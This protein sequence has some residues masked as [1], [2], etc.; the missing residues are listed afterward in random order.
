MKIKQFLETIE[1]LSVNTQKNYE[2]TLWQINQVIRGDEPTDEDIL[3][4]LKRYP[5]SSLHRH[6]AA[7]KAYVE[8]RDKELKD[9]GEKG[10]PW[11]F[12][13]RQFAAKRQRIPR[14]VSPQV[15]QEIIN[16]G[17]TEDETMFVETL[18]QLG[19]RISELMSI[20]EKKITA[21]GVQVITKGG[22][23]YL[24]LTTKE[25]NQTLRAYA[26]KKKGRV[27]PRTYSY[28]DQ[29]LKRLAEKAGHS[30]VTLHMIRHGRAVDLLR[31]GMQLTDVQQ[32]LHHKSIT[33]TA[34]YL[35][36]TGGELAEQL[37]RVEANDAKVS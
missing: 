15:V 34:I 27:F 11:P 1:G 36:I 29:L 25:F 14:Y 21:A 4:F 19:C 35:Q 2:Q 9:K 31:K 16:A 32:F 24:K 5:P 18:F 37:E 12:T 33:T 17:E 13:R 7:I 23:E 22:D 6:K 28:Y 30:D 3:K 20:D 26:L 8:F 10:W